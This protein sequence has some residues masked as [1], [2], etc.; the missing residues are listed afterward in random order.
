MCIPYIIPDPPSKK[1]PR[2]SGLIVQSSP[3]KSPRLQPAI[4]EISPR[5]TYVASPKPNRSPIPRGRPS[6][7]K[8]PRTP[9]AAFL[10]GFAA[11]EQASR[12]EEGRVLK[13]E[14]PPQKPESPSQKPE[15]PTKPT[16]PTMDKSPPPQEPV[17]LPAPLANPKKFHSPPPPALHHP[18][19]LPFAPSPHPPQQKPYTPIHSP[20]SYIRRP[21]HPTHRSRSLSADS[22]ISR[23][24]FERLKHN[25][26]FLLER[27]KVLEAEKE[28]REVSRRRPGREGNATR[29]KREGSLIRERRQRA[30]EEEERWD[31][32]GGGLG[33]R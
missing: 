4:I 23:R 29:G 2:K 6:A 28:G 31:W 22:T 5:L 19:T 13:D 1:R 26:K 11:G 10:E 25:L 20:Y 14:T 27:V 8:P 21:P 15:P 32:E 16:S 18:R 7:M 12:Q 17:D 33:R 24:S 9:E 3:P 30:R